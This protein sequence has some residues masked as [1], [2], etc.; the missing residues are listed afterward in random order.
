MHTAFFKYTNFLG[1]RLREVVG[2]RVFGE[3][4]G[5]LRA[6]IGKLLISGGGCL[7]YFTSIAPDDPAFLGVI[8][9]RA[10]AGWERG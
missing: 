4:L 1:V 7:G 6:C 2:R 5:A 9:L 10:G 8:L 3:G